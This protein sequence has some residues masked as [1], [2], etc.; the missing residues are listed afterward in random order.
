MGKGIGGRPRK[1]DEKR[2]QRMTLLL[3]E[4]E[5]EIVSTAARL[6]SMPLAIFGRSIILKYAKEVLKR[7]R[8]ASG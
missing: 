7:E 8:V 1:G 4:S 5:Q 6:E 3:D 2:E